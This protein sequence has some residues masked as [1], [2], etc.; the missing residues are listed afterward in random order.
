[1]IR[2]RF[3][4]VAAAWLTAS[5]AAAQP[6]TVTDFGPVP[7]DLSI[8][9]ATQSQQDHSVARGGNQYL[10]VWSDY[11]G[12]AAGGG[13]NQQGGEIFG[14]RL[15]ASGAPVDAMPFR[16]AGGMG[17]QRQPIVAWNGSAWLVLY[18]SQE[19][20]EYYYEDRI[21]AVRVSAAGQVLD[22]AP[23]VLPADAFTPSTVG[24]NL[25]G[26]AGEWLITRAVYHSDGY[27]NFLG[28]QR[29]SAGGT[30]LDATPLV[31][32]DWIWG[33]T[34]ALPSNGEYVVAAAD[35]YGSGNVRARRVS[36]S[37]QPIG[38]EFSLP[39]LQVATSGAELYV[40]WIKDYV[41]LV[42]SRVSNSGVL[43]TPAGTPIVTN[44]SSYTHSTLT[45]DGTQWWL[46]WGVSDLLHTV[47]INAAGTVLDAGGGPLLPITIGGNVNTAYGVQMV[48]RPG[49]GVLVFWYDLRVALG[50]DTNVWTI[51]VSA[52]NTAGAE[53]AVSTGTRTQRAPDLSAGPGLVSALAFVSEA[54][55]DR[56]VLVHFLDEDGVATTAIPI[57]VASATSIGRASIAWNGAVYLVVWD[58]GA[59][60]QVRGRRLN[61]DGSFVDATPF[62]VMPG[63]APDVESLGEDFLVACSRY[64]TYPQYI[65]A[66]MRIVDGPTRAFQNPA[67]LIGGNYVNVGPRVRRGPGR[68]IVTYHSHWTHDSSQSDAVFN[69]V[70]A[71][72][73]FT[74]ASNPCAT[75]GGSGT[76]DV[77][78]SGQQYLWVWRNNSLSNANNY[79]AGRIMNADGTFATGHVLIAEAT[80]RQL[81][82]SVGWDGANFL[83]VWDDQRNQQAFFDE[84]TEIYGARV[85]PTGSVV[86]P[87][88][89]GIQTGPTGGATGEVLT[90]SDGH[91]IVASAR[92]CTSG[93]HD[94]YRIGTTYVGYV[95]ALAADGP[96]VGRANLAPAAPNP[97]RG[98]TTLTFALP[99]A[100]RAVLA[101]LDL[102]GR[103]V[104]T[105]TTGERAAGRHTLTWD[106]RDD[107]G[108]ATAP[109]L[110][111]VV[112]RTGAGTQTRRIV[113]LGE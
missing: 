86:D 2:L 62:D 21:C 107:A 85:A 88:A 59:T 32:L 61:A 72:G 109:G 73:T 48:S 26:Q 41:N 113:R 96:A 84:R 55:N 43:A 7:G 51:P 67:T 56:R 92:W 38:A 66:W 15:D 54:A 45:H 18:V 34:V 81:R 9:T 104:R 110:Y 70:F 52:A 23:I 80:G 95:A 3:V 75:S 87:D 53:R 39:S 47:R 103:A 40:V 8:A 83:V 101:V 24:L 112:L 17:L 105:L 37:G 65:N 30:L 49:G 10:V 77:A 14:I 60:G 94:S 71:D 76:P 19:P 58:D 11:R 64:A 1:M 74:P 68:W 29:I 6:P 20:T 79:I 46:E 98:S 69:F 50:Y 100:D 111:L 42:G 13:T 90:R 63:F 31:L 16:I 82:P 5:L 35:F 36:T 102:Q 27:G 12:Q 25:T 4:L 93:P 57:E 91:S 28:G 78:W 22:S 97:S 108:V 33:D 99:R 106:G 44:F 89:F